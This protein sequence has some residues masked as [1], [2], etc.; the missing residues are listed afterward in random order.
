MIDFEQGKKLKL[1]EM[2]LEAKFITQEQLKNA[3]AVQKST[4]QRLGAVI[5]NLGYV[6]EAMMINFVAQQQELRI[7]NLEE[8]VLPMGLIQKIPRVLIEKYCLLP[9]SL[10]DDAMTIVMNDP[11][12]YE[13]IE[14]IQLVGNWRIEVVLAPRSSIRRTIEDLF[15]QQKSRLSVE[16][17]N[18]KLDVLIQ[19]LI[20]KKIITQKGFNKIL[21]Q[22]QKH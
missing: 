8:M 21:D 3:L 18:H 5:E 11:T 14:E 15:S 22:S 17:I 2:L 6:D 12:D 20:D 10:K 4:G 13:A 19:L 1:G 16:S 9:I 7:V